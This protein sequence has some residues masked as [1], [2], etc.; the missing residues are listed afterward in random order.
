VH[1]GNKSHVAA[2]EPIIDFTDFVDS[3][4]LS[5]RQI[6]RLAEVTGLPITFTDL[7]GLQ[8]I[9]LARATVKVAAQRMNVDLSRASRHLA[10]LN[11]LGLVDRAADGNDGRTVWVSL[12]ESGAAALASWQSAWA[13]DYLTA[14][15][16]WRLPEVR[17][18]GTLVGRFQQ[19]QAGSLL[20]IPDPH[21]QFIA[22]AGVATDDWPFLGLPPNG[23]SRARALL[24][25][26]RFVD[27][28][29]LSSAASENRIYEQSKSPVKANLIRLLGVIAHR[30]PM[31][32]NQLA[33][34]LPEGPSPSG[35]SRYISQLEKHGLVVRA[36]DPLDG[37]SSFVKVSPKGAMLLRRVRLN[38]AQ[39]AARIVESWAP[40]D[41]EFLSSNFGRLLSAVTETE[42]K[43]TSSWVGRPSVGML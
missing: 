23:D 28:V 29:P 27:W 37:R 42:R 31:R 20:D 30:G 35:A 14:V 9:A 32:I 33:G 39:S 25:V 2:A 11:S 7:H 34:R 8:I 18:F 12:S 5:K 6:A 13:A 22:A 3:R 38:S 24:P 26:L 4:Q 17:R 16:N 43:A 21:T 19:G 1:E 36:V 40:E 10:Y 41:I 15:S